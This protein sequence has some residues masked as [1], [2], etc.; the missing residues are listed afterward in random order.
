MSTA[1]WGEPEPQSEERYPLSLLKALL[2][3]MMRQFGAQGAVIALY[4]EVIGQMVV[5]LHVRWGTR[6]RRLC[7]A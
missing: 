6:P 7:S 3:Q 1:I 4:D 5:R 2:Q